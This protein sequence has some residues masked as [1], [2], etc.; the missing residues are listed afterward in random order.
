MPPKRRPDVRYYNSAPAE[1]LRQEY[2]KDLEWPS[3][4]DWSNPDKI[5]LKDRVKELECCVQYLKNKLQ[6]LE[7]KID[8]DV[9]A[10]QDQVDECVNK[11]DFDDLEEKV[12][13]IG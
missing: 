6:K 13:E 1:V 5:T 10:L 7:D 9:Q 4:V 3:V 8:E 11:S 2:V 12:K